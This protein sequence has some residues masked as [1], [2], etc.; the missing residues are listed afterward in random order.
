MQKEKD[1][2]ISDIN[3]VIHSFESNDSSNNEQTI[4]LKKIIE[5]L[6]PIECVIEDL[7]NLTKGLD[8]KIKKT[9]NSIK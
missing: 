8:R 3:Y 7:N 5:S 4:K 9:I 2:L 6:E 1:T